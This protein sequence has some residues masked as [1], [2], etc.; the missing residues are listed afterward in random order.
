[1]LVSIAS[2]RNV[3][4]VYKYDINTSVKKIF[5]AFLS[6]MSLCHLQHLKIV[7]YNAKFNMFQVIFQFGIKRFLYYTKFATN[8]TKTTFWMGVEPT[9]KIS[10]F[11]ALGE[12]L[13]YQDYL[14]VVFMNYYRNNYVY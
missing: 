11:S 12:G 14:C 9:S 1:M 4:Q 13:K 10:T 5:L 7:F 2:I 8:C 3:I 6:A